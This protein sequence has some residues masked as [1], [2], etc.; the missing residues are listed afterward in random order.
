[1]PNASAISSAKAALTTTTANAL[2]SNIS[3]PRR[4]VGSAIIATPVCA[5]ASWSG[6]A[7]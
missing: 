3:G 1:M 6:A 7:V 5:S 2:P 4:W